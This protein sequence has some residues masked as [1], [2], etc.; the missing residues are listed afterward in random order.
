MCVLT[1]VS[2]HVTYQNISETCH[3]VCY[4]LLLQQKYGITKNMCPRVTQCI[5]LYI[6][7]KCEKL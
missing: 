3:Q 7:I 4:F 2:L 1:A 6:L 5:S